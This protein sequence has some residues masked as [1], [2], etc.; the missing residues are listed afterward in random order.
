MLQRNPIALA[1]AG[2]AAGKRHIYNNTGKADKDSN[3]AGTTATSDNGD[4]EK[5]SDQQKK[6]FISEDQVDVGLQISSALMYLHEKSIIF[7]GK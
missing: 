2:V 6:A 3:G 4:Q 7:R 5:S 1:G